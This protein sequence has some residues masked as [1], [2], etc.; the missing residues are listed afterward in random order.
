MQEFNIPGRAVSV[1]R[2]GEVLYKQ[3]YGYANSE[4]KQPVT[5]K[6][7]IRIA[8]LSKFI[9]GMA[10]NLLIQDG[11]IS[12][13]TKVFAYLKLEPFNVATPFDERVKK[14]TVRHLLHMRSGMNLGCGEIPRD[15]WQKLGM[16]IPYSQQ[17]AVRWAFAQP[18]EAEPGV[19]FGYNNGGFMVLGEMVRKAS[20]MTYLE[21]VNT[22]ICDPLR[23]EH[24]REARW[25]REDQYPGEVTYY[26]RNLKPGP[27][28]LP[29]DHGK[30]VEPPYGAYTAG[31]APYGG[32]WIGVQP[33]YTDQD[34]VLS[35]SPNSRGKT[36]L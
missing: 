3:G 36:F 28:L 23:I 6:S 4:T 12:M 21:F 7:L 18:M 11:T 26:E 24:F 1:L 5:N 35:R 16:S 15:H 27:S 32:R 13:D 22:R 19:T 9:T 10:I 8:S 34:S 33:R 25:R 20:G 29:E 17:D 14:I 31:Y 2:D 30:V